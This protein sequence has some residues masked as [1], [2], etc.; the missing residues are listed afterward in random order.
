MHNL[1][2]FSERCKFFL[3]VENVI[4]LALYVHKAVPSDNI[5]INIYINMLYLHSICKGFI[6]NFN[7]P[8]LNEI[9][10][11]QQLSVSKMEN[12]IPSL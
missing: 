6:P 2:L 7:L 5:C 9:E 8:F 3:H 11:N 12:I 1:T 4:F 10:L